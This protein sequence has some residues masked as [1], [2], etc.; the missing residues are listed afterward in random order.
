MVGLDGVEVDLEEQRRQHDEIVPADKN[1]LDV[2]LAF[3][4]LL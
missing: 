4:R 1:D 2:R 3:A